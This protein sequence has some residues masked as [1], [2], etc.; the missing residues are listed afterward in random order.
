MQSASLHGVVDLARYPLDAPHGAAYAD[1]VRE[2]RAELEETGC[3]VLRGFLESDAV[4]TMRDQ[5]LPLTG[6]AF[7]HPRWV[8]AYSTV[9]DPSFPPD[10]PRRIFMKRT[11]GFVAKDRIPDDALLRGLYGSLVFQ[12]FVADCLGKE[13]IYEYADPLA[14][15]VVNVLP[16][17]AEHPW[18][19][20]TNEFIV[21]TLLAPADEGG[22]FEY[23]PNIRSPGDERY[24]RVGRVIRGEDRSEVRELR[25]E[26]GDLQLFLGRFT[27]HRVTEVRSDRPRLTAI[28]AYAQE[29]GMIGKPERT[30][31]LFG[32]I[33]DAHLQAAKERND[34]LVD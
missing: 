14:S 30:R 8:N 19:Y 9:D 25:L 16:R 28:L 7:Y 5:A 13:V 33:T 27:L 11:H 12:R 23:C 1:V 17:G 22:V 18:H 31:Q 10:H 26:S 15:L 32:R 29:P 2:V 3:S 4:T 34:G 20:D 24:D 21:S 6:Q